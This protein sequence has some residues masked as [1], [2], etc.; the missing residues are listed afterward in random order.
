MGAR[1]Q[2]N[3]R[4]IKAPTAIGIMRLI[5]TER[6]PVQAVPIRRSTLL[7]RIRIALLLSYEVERSQVLSFFLR[8]I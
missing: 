2:V 1:R 3:V 7:V 5:A 4:M 6:V 8:A